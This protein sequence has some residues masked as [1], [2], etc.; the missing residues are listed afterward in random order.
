M[1][2][3]MKFAC[4]MA[5]YQRF[6]AG[7]LLASSPARHRVDPAFMLLGWPDGAAWNDGTEKRLYLTSLPLYSAMTRQSGDYVLPE[8]A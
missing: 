5:A 2:Q 4:G 8:G 6:G 3:N 1:E 7:D